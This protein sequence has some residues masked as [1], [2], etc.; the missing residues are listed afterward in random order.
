MADARRLQVDVLYQVFAECCAAGFLDVQKDHDVAAVDI[1]AE[2]FLEDRFET[3]EMRRFEDFVF[4]QMARH[5][6]EAVA[7]GWR[8]RRTTETSQT[9]IHVEGDHAKDQDKQEDQNAKSETSE[10]DENY[11]GISTNS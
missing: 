1:E 2:V 3:D 10:R 4:R 7:R 9:R 8:R 5:K 6:F 11:A